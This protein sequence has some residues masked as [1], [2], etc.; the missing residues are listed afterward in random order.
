MLAQEQAGRVTAWEADLAKYRA[1][2]AAPNSARRT[3]GSL[4]GNV[5][6]GSSGY[7]TTADMV[8]ISPSNAFAG[9][10]PSWARTRSLNSTRYVTGREPAPP[11]AALASQGCLPLLRSSARRHSAPPCD[12]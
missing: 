7:S 2:P 1:N 5:R 12:G 10:S 6:I 9:K 4:V 3:Y 8:A 11:P